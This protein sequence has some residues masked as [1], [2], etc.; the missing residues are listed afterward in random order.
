MKSFSAL[1]LLLCSSSVL[2]ED[3]DDSWSSAIGCRVYHADRTKKYNEA[4]NDCVSL[5]HGEYFAMTF[6]NSIWHRSVGVGYMHVSPVTDNLSVGYSATV[7]TGYN[8]TGVPVVF[9]FATAS[10]SLR[11]L[12]DFGS[13][14]AIDLSSNYIVTQVQLRY[15]FEGDSNRPGKG[16]SDSDWAMDYSYGTDGGRIS[17]LRQVSPESILPAGMY[18]SGTFTL[19]S[20]THERNG[21]TDLPNKQSIGQKGVMLSLAWFPG[22]NRWLGAYAGVGVTQVH[23]HSSYA[24]SPSVVADSTAHHQDTYQAPDLGGISL[25]LHTKASED[26]KWGT[27]IQ[28]VVGIRLGNPYGSDTPVKIYLDIGARRLPPPRKDIALEFPGA[29]STDQLM[30]S[31]AISRKFLGGNTTEK[32]EKKRWLPA[33]QIGVDVRF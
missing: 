29:S 1:L 18:A 28:P 3:F 21:W 30:L 33:V 31:N 4:H 16:L 20:V 22:N 13:H 25:P 26:I 27:S 14:F 9:P 2:A 24:L 11:G 10:Y 12:G 19:G 17:L 23:Y 8:P 32:W 5:Q 7:L 6:R 15:K